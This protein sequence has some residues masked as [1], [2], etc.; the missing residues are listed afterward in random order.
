MTCPKEE[1]VLIICQLPTFVAHIL[2]NVLSIEH[3][4]CG[5]FF[6]YFTPLCNL[7]ITVNSAI[8]FLIYFLFNK[9]FRTVFQETLC[10]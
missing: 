6:H 3:R 2:W 1:L 8:N 4:E 9:R 10:K 5:G 7:L